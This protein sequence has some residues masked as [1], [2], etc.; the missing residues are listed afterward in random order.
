MTRHP[1]PAGPSG[2]SQPDHYPGLLDSNAAA[3]MLAAA[4]DVSL[5]L[6]SAGT[7]L[8]IAVAERDLVVL[9]FGTW[10]GRDWRDTVT[11]DSLPKIDEMLA[12]AIAGR[13]ARWRQVNQTTDNGEVPVRYLA[14]ALGKDGRVVA[15]GRDMRAQAATQQRLI[16]AQ[17]SLERDYIRLRQVEARY[18]LLFDMGREAVLVIDAATRRIREANVAAHRLVDAKPGALVDQPA[19]MLVEAADRER[20]VAYLGAAAV[21]VTPP[22]EVLM[23]RKGI[24]EGRFVATLFRQERAALLLLRIE[25]TAVGAQVSDES[26]PLRDVVDALPDAFVLADADMRVLT[27]NASFLELAELPVLDRMTGGALGEWLGRPGIDLEVIETQ[28]REHGTVRNVATIMRGSSGGEEEVELSGVAVPGT[29]GSMHFGFTIRTL[30][31]RVVDTAQP[32]RE[33]PRSV[34][35]LTELV[36]RMS[37]KEIVREST[38]LIERLCIEAALAHTSDNRASAAE[39]LGVSRQSLYSKLHRHGLGSLTSEPQ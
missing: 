31:R 21:A 15:I 20:L 39:I 27:A 3:Q 14:M 4:G 5:V 19:T 18:R 17:Q 29:D 8:D 25:P 11:R 12:D 10:A 37:L 30:A 28:L 13:P 23:L 34:E 7:I 24:G 9:G 26:L 1:A 2:F 36:G 6:D 22:T 33:V 32:G 16:Q 38:D 35:Q